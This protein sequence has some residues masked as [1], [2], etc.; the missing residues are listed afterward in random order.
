M[1]RG[2]VAPLE[3]IFKP[4][5]LYGV[6]NNEPPIGATTQFTHVRP[7]TVTRS[8]SVLA[9]T[10]VTTFDW[11]VLYWADAASSTT[12]TNLGTGGSTYDT[13]FAGGT[14]S[15]VDVGPNQDY[16]DISGT[17]RAQVPDGSLTDFIYGESFMM[18]I[19]L[20]INTSLSGKRPW[21]SGAQFNTGADPGWHIDAG[22][23]F[24]IERTT[25]TP[26]RYTAN[27]PGAPN[28]DEIVVF[29]VRYDSSTDQIT[30]F[31][32]GVAGT[33]VTIAS[34]TYTNAHTKDI[35]RIGGLAPS[36]NY[37]DGRYYKA[38]IAKGVVLSDSD[39]AALAATWGYD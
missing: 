4:E 12:L 35:G 20:R 8:V 26:K 10:E 24:T 29:V 33:P 6:V 17:S 27:T 31:V 38:G 28:A 23:S 13:S 22:G 14:Q 36:S 15:H 19:R 18:A 32:N 9:P 34:G 3:P 11:G 16:W 39:I 5:I 7:S 37:C 21:G 1:R 30:A 25:G 2:P